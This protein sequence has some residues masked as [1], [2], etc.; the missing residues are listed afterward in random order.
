M[1][2]SVQRLSILLTVARE[3]GIQA[4]ADVLGVSASAVS[5]QMNKLEHECGHTLLVRTASGA[6]LTDAG[7]LVAQV[8]Q[9]VE[10]ECEHLER[11]L[12]EYAGTP[13]GIVRV[14]AFQTV[15]RSLILP[16][17]EA[18]AEQAPGV[19]VHVREG[20]SRASLA[21]LRQNTIDI[22]VLES[23]TDVPTAPRGTR[24]YPLL[25][26]PWYVVY[27]AR[28]AL[29]ADPRELVQYPWLG[30]H[31][32]SVVG[33]ATERLARSWGFTPSQQYVFQDYDVAL[34]MVQ[35]GL[36]VAV[37]PRLGLADRRE[38]IKVHYV[39]GLGTRQLVMCISSAPSR[40]NTAIDLICRQLRTIALGASELI[41]IKPATA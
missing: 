22:A 24:I 5:Q 30:A 13:T 36:G 35:A 17:L 1:K 8:A 2:I 11:D 12:L 3:G 6:I 29:P 14:G 9:Q 28:F 31:P 27:P 15:I 18:L 21:Y 34:S 4:A 33:R 41:D 39:P 19:D 20:D 26:E 37:L 25:E 32:D 7:R 23:D 38:G 16:N 10:Q 40:Q